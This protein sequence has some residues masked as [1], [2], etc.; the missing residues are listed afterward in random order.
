M[1]EV[2]NLISDLFWISY[3]YYCFLSADR[4]VGLL[5]ENKLEQVPKNLEAWF[6]S[7]VILYTFHIAFLSLKKKS[8]LSGL[9]T[10]ISENS[11]MNEARI[12][13]K[14]MQG[15]KI[16]TRKRRRQLAYFSL[17]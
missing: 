6:T 7:I 8:I 9:P 13:K 17:L 2:C 3:T 10:M 15:L 4:F 1:L 12:E 16:V 14:A 5:E 11:Y